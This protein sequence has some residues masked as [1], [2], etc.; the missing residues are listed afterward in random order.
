[1]E[2]SGVER[3]RIE[4]NGME[5][6]RGKDWNTVEGSAVKWRGKWK[7]PG[8]SGIEWSAVE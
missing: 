3:N 2:W 7:G 6:N 8:M 5:W 4:W 1:M